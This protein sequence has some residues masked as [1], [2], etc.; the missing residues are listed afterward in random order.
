MVSITARELED[1]LK[2][3]GRC[4]RH[5]GRA[6]LVGGSSLILTEAKYSTLDIDL[7]L[8]IPDEYYQEFIRC[9]RETSRQQQIPV[10]EASPDQFI[11]LPVGYEDRHQFI[12]RYGSLDVF[13]F[14]FYSVALSKL[15]RGNDKD[16]QDVIEMVV[17]GLI[18][19]GQLEEQFQEVLPKLESFSIMDD[20]EEFQHNFDIFKERLL[21]A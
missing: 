3:I 8:E 4:Y 20:A 11:P 6:Y 19:I 21:Q 18:A 12:G 16:Y 17:Q 7:K 14:D 5:S 2:R 9:L 13:H 10:E 15:H 1:F